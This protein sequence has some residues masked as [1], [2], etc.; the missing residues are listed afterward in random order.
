MPAPAAPGRPRSFRR[1]EPAGV[2]AVGSGLRRCARLADCSRVSRAPRPGLRRS[3]RG[4]RPSP[5]VARP[6]PSPRAPRSRRRPEHSEW[7]TLRA[8]RREG[9][10]RAHS[11]GGSLR[12]K[13][14]GTT[15]R[16]AAGGDDRGGAAEACSG[17]RGPPPTAPPPPPPTPPPQPSPPPRRPRGGT[18]LVGRGGPRLRA[19]SVES[20]RRWCVGFGWEREAVAYAGPSPPA[21]SPSSPLAL[22]PPSLMLPRPRHRRPAK[23]DRARRAEGGGVTEGE[24]RPRA[25]RRADGSAS[26]TQGGSA[27][28]P[29]AWPAASLPDVRPFLASA[30]AGATRPRVDDH[31]RATNRPRASPRARPVPR[32]LLRPRQ[33][34][35]RSPLG[36]GAG[37]PSILLFTLTKGVP[38]PSFA[39]GS[40]QGIFS[41]GE[42]GGEW[43]AGRGPQRP[44]NL[45]TDEPFR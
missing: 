38:M 32:R 19:R 27:A 15:R 20:R 24:R 44:V 17:S 16:T 2:A 23:G 9:R 7:Q 37:P 12:T 43:T 22:C 3:G 40:G 31:L 39:D 1:A 4:A 25:R 14:P 36:S 29:R 21:P 11:T 5:A 35:G 41:P 45:R 13:G 6:R 42:A 8:T 34:S 18:S 10:A 26:S 28:R 30:R 33:K